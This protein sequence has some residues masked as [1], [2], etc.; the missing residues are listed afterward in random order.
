MTKIGDED[1]IQV[2]YQ[3]ATQS[4]RVINDTYNSILA[5]VGLPSCT[6]MR[7]V[8]K[9]W[10]DACV[11]RIQDSPAAQTYS[12]SSLGNHTDNTSRTRYGLSLDTVVQVSGVV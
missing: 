1:A 2:P 4:V 3:L 5:S 11:A 6:H 8:K 9:A 7:Q 12:A 10:A